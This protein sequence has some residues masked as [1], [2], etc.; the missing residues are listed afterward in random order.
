[1]EKERD[2]FRQR[3]RDVCTEREEIEI[4]RESQQIHK[5]KTSDIAGNMLAFFK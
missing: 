2:V 3:E 4:C 5:K 1:M